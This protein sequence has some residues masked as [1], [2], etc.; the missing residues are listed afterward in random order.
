MTDKKGKSKGIKK[1]KRISG[2][3]VRVRRTMQSLIV[4]DKLAELPADIPSYLTSRARPVKAKANDD[5]E[6]E[7]REKKEKGDRKDG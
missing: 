5:E 4:Q 2:G 1:K 7:K 6:E 3:G